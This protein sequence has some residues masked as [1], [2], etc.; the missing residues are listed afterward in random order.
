V[1]ARLLLMTNSP[2]PLLESS[3]PPRRWGR[4]KEREMRGKDE[5]KGRKVGTGPPIG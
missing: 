1:G 2:G 3:N 4:G 5:R